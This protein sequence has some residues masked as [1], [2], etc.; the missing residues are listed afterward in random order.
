MNVFPQMPILSTCIHNHQPVFNFFHGF[1]AGNW[2]PLP[3]TGGLL[4]L[5][6]QFLV[7]PTPPWWTYLQKV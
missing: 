7:K 1:W 2:R 3:M 4:N 5:A 6:R